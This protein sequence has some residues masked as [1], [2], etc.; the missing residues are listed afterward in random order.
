MVSVEGDSGGDIPYVIT[1][2]TNTIPELS[3]LDLRIKAVDAAIELYAD[4]T[5]ANFG[6]YNAKFKELYTEI[7]N[8]YGTSK[9]LH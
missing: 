2:T 6:D 3:D 1:T 8:F 7:Y 4:K 9:E 5:V